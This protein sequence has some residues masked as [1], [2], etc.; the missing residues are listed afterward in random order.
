[1]KKKIFLS[2][3]VSLFVLTGCDV[4]ENKESTDVNS[5]IENEIGIKNYT[6]SSNSTEVIDEGGRTDY[7]WHVKYDNIEF[8]VID[9]YYV[10][11]DFGVSNTRNSLRSNFDYNVLKYYYN[12]Y[13][14]KDIVVYESDSHN[15]I[16]DIADENKHVDESKLRTCYNNSIDFINIL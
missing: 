1:M 6:L 14:Y 12:N 11:N 8:D 3:L 9:D 13:S 2:L 4:S 7:Y 15:I 16:C 5:Y 10:S